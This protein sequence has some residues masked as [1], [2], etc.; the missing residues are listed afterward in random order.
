[1]TDPRWGLV[2]RISNDYEPQFPVVGEDVPWP[3]ARDVVASQVGAVRP[4]ETV[5]QRALAVG[6]GFRLP[7]SDSDDSDDDVLSVGPVRPLSTAASMGGVRRDDECWLW[8]DLLNDALSVEAWATENRHETCC[9][10]LDNFDWVVPPYDLAVMLP[11]P[12][13]DEESSDIERDVCDVPDEFPV[14]MD[15]AAVKLLC[16]P[17]VV[18]TRPQVAV[19]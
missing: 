11:R 19:T 10:R 4:L 6:E 5:D 2:A 12:E 14:N 17:G 16:L 9:A 18:Q 13:L 7:C 1:M 3:A 8:A 15:K